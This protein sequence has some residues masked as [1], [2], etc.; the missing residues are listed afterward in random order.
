VGDI[1]VLPDWLAQ[2]PAEE[3]I[4]TIAA[5]GAYDTRVCHQ[6][7]PERRGGGVAATGRRPTAST[8]GD[9]G[10]HSTIRTHSLETAQWLSPAQPG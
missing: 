2:L 1:E 8:H 6:V 9:S 5:D 10:H 4:A 3:S 7:L